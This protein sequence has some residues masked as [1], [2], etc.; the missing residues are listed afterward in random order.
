MVIKKTK[1]G[2]VLYSHSGKRLSKPGSKAAAIKR[3]KQVKYFKSK[4]GRGS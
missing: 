4:K 2:Y 3:E 1:K